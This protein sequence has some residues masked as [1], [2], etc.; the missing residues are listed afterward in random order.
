MK[1]DV[2]S[3][4]KK[5]EQVIWAKTE[6]P[7]VIINNEGLITEHLLRA[8]HSSNYYTCF[9]TVFEKLAVQMLK[10]KVSP[11]WFYCTLTSG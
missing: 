3:P 2:K 9:I 8:R 11:Q 6:G 4:S 5:E 1:G 10:R 7:F